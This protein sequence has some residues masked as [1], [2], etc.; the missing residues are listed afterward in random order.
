MGDKGSLM[1]R[2]L[3]NAEKFSDKQVAE[4]LQLLVTHGFKR[5]ASDI[6]IEPHER[7]VLVRY[8]IDGSL[9]GMHKLPRQALGIVMAELKKQ[10]NLRVQET[11]TPQEGQYDVRIGETDVTVHV[12][13]MPVYGGE[14]A[15][16]HLSVRMDRPGA[17]HELGF[18]GAGLKTLRAVMASPHGLVTVAAPRHNGIA[19]TLFSFLD[20]LNSPMVSIA[21]IELRT[22]HRL[23][24][25]SQ[26]YLAA[27]D[28]NVHEGLQA[29]MK[30]DPNI[31]MLGDMPDRGTAELA[32][33]A[34]TTGHLVIVGMHAGSA[35]AGALRM[36]VAG[37]EPFLL[38]TALRAS[39]GQRLVRTLCP[40]CRQ[41]YKLSQDEQKQLAEQFGITGPAAYK[42]IHDLER[43]AAL[44]GFGELK[45]FGSNPAGITH[46]WRPDPD[47]CE[48][49]EH[50]GYEGRTAIVEV[51]SN[52]DQ[53]HKALMGQ[54]V[55][56]VSVVQKA[57]LKDG[58]VPMALDGLVKA[59]RGQ[60]TTTE[61]LRAAGLSSLA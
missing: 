38:V 23:P 15:V 26:T 35:V 3:G 43:A 48:A 27:S 17:L 5:G 52:T 39:I 4:T 28:M 49:C 8:R 44:A 42:R 61:V 55:D 41:Q 7:F 45:Q 30:Q 29:A 2:L 31:I 25:V 33:H 54:S 59:L 53:L 34:A 11:T 6:H 24:G 21:T 60:T 9:R 58:F 50:T 12:S 57:V 18:W 1:S 16:L 51:L 56:S 22:K 47:G 19:S 36:R 10:A 37:A 32:V 14:K 20:Q 40:D 13:I 46:L